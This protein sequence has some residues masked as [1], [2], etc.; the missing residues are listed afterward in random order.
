[1]GRLRMRSACPDDTVKCNGLF[2]FLSE[3]YLV[4][5]FALP[6]D[7]SRGWSIW[8]RSAAFSTSP[9]CFSIFLFCFSLTCSYFFEWRG[10]IYLGVLR[11]CPTVSCQTILI[12]G[13]VEVGP[14]TPPHKICPMQKTKVKVGVA[15]WVS[16][17][18]WFWWGAWLCSRFPQCIWQAYCQW[19][20]QAIA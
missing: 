13:L 3:Q 10:Y 8:M 19:Q 12:S 16:T 11:P 18:I 14:G 17:P 1:M 7:F 2:I 9:S 4:P 5:V 6:V 20:V 15:V